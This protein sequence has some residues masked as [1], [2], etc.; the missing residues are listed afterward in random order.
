[1][2]GERQQVRLAVAAF[3]GGTRPAND[4]TVCFQ[5][6]PL[7][8]YGLGTAYPY[9]VRGVPDEYFTI[10]APP[11]RNWGCVLGLGRV[12]RLTK[13]DS[14]AGPTSGYWQRLY[15]ITC[16][17]AV[18]TELPHIEVA[19]AGLDALIDQ[20]HSLVYAD[21][22]L[23]TTTPDSILI[24]QAG[25]GK[26]GLRDVTD[27]FEEID[28]KRGRYAAMASVTFEALTMVTQ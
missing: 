23:G 17:I 27:K 8:A 28:A 1:M 4:P 21:R 2:A 15:G 13:L 11:G 16:E 24:L 26:A 12:E 14:M 6:G 10:G 22:T 25:A 19:G 7:A 20:M 18:L 9:S 5:G 3:F